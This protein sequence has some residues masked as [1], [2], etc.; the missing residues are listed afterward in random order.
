MKSTASKNK[1][2]WQERAQQP[3]ENRTPPNRTLQCPAEIAGEAGQ[4][5]K[6]GTHRP[7]DWGN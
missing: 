4:R 2:Q 1:S 5:A 7:A 3:L 6:Q